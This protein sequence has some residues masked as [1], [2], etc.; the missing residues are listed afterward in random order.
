MMYTRVNEDWPVEAQEPSSGR[1]VLRFASQYVPRRMRA[2]PTHW[3]RS[4]ALAG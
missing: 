4:T 1:R 2:S 3:L